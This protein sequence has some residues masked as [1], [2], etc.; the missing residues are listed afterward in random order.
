MDKV[1]LKLIVDL[2]MI[3]SLVILILTGFLMSPISYRLGI[4]V[5]GPVVVNAH[6]VSSIAFTLLVIIHVALGWNRLK[7]MLF[8][9]K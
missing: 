9:K 3:L 5:K 6:D 2:L 1:K 8:G 4:T 7:E